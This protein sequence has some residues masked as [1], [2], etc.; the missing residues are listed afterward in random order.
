V[1]CV[2]TL[3]RAAR[4][5]LG[6]VV[7]VTIAWAVPATGQLKP[8]P[9]LGSRIPVEPEKLKQ[10]KTRQV[11]SDYASCV[12]KKQRPLASQFVLDRT[13]LRFEK[14]Y[15]P[16][17]D[18]NCLLDATGAYFAEVGMGLGED[19]MRFA[20]AEA[21]LRDEI[22]TIDPGR[23]PQAV[24]LQLPLLATADYEPKIGKEYRADDLKALDEERQKDQT[25]LIMYR[26]GDCVVRTDP[27]RARA[28]VQAAANS[29][30]E[31]VALQAITPA[32]GACLEKGAQLK[33]N[34]S[35]LRGELAFSYY[36]LAHAPAAPPTHAVTSQR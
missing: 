15:R 10:D 19:T 35:I 7:L 3:S 28:V 16:L 33:L 27:Q 25:T 9:H 14:K 4:C 12:V 18:G 30:A 13:T 32:F 34:R 8:E 36:S 1:F 24:Q 11:L 6:A 29:D 5:A 20:L 21:L 17:A 26:F 2:Q 22:A 23:L 31:A